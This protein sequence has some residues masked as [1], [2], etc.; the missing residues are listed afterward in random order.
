MTNKINKNTKIVEIPCVECGCMLKFRIKDD[1]VVGGDG[2]IACN[3]PGG[4]CPDCV[5]SLLDKVADPPGLVCI[6]ELSPILA[7][8]LLLNFTFLRS[9][10]EAIGFFISLFPQSENELRNIL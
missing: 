1:I 4:V 3:V 2:R 10:S 7:Q 6:N 9:Q 5:E 8:E